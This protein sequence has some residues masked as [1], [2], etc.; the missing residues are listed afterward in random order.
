VY[1]A[2]GLRQHAVSTM[3][4]NTPAATRFTLFDTALGRCG[5][6]WNDEGV[7]ALQLPEASDR[8]TQARMLRSLGEAQSAV[9]SADVQAAIDR[10]VALTQGRR[11]DLKEVRLDM[12]EVPPFNR[13]VYR[14]ARDIPPGQTL[15]Y[16]AMAERLGDASLARA[17]GQALGQNPFAVIVPCHRVLAAGGR[18]GGF[19]ANGG[20]ATKLRLL[21]IER[22]QIG[23]EPGLFDVE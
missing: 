23:S 2:A 7:L 14:L 16:G 4:E 17:V 9:P 20:V 5:I 18:S 15:T 19:S 3:N 21:L 10:V 1:E 12:R 6:A 8:A 11:I 22:A 13:R